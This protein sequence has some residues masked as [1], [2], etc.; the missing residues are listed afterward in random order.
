MIDF[1]P[2]KEKMEKSLLKFREEIGGIRTGR[3]SASLVENLLCSVYQGT[4]NLRLKEL[5]S[6]TSP[7]P[8]SLLIQPWD[9]SVIGEVK[10]SILAANI[11][12]TPV[13]EGSAVRIA[14]PPLTGERRQEYIKLLGQKSEEARIAVRNI[15]RDQMES[16]KDSFEGKNLSEDEKFRAEAELQKITD[17]FIAKIQEAEK[18]KEEELLQ[19]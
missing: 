1:N 8:Q 16:I 6:I 19:V 10:Q 14:V 4:Q 9:G 17:G 7:D 13:V 15:R 11:G 12:L 3:A 2:T 5:A 18:K